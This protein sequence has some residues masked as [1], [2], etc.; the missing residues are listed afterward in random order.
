[1]R[2]NVGDAGGARMD[3]TTEQI[4]YCGLPAGS[5][6]TWEK[7]ERGLRIVVPPGGFLLAAGSLLVSFGLATLLVITM[8][9]CAILWLA[10]KW[11]VPV[12]HVLR[13]YVRHY[14]SE[15]ARTGVIPLVLFGIVS[16]IVAVAVVVA[17]WMLLT[18]GCQIELNEKELVV[19]STPRWFRSRRRA[20]QRGAIRAVRRRLRAVIVIDKRGWHWLRGGV[21]GGFSRAELDWIVWQLQEQLRIGAAEQPAAT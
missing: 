16:V 11:S 17:L 2:P 1:M 15:F 6:I 8:H 10:R 7:N 19:T 4:A 20:W 18:Q 5:R 13:P 12:S 9:L 14:V 21:V 3:S